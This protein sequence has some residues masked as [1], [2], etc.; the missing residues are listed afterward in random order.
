MVCTKLTHCIYNVMY[1]ILRA[2]CLN[3]VSEDYS[4]VFNHRMIANRASDFFLSRG[5]RNNNAM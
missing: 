3:G 1:S 2:E 4:A 5:K